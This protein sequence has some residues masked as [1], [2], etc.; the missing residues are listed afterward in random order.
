MASNRTGR[1][2]RSKDRVAWKSTVDIIPEFKL[3]PYRELADAIIGQACH[4]YVYT[5]NDKMLKEVTEFFE[6]KKDSWFN[7]ICDL[8][9]EYLLAA[10]RVE[11]TK[12]LAKNARL[13]RSDRIGKHRKL[14]NGVWYTA[15]K[16]IGEYED[17]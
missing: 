15:Q 17:E 5:N 3:M 1:P 7:E 6:C 9:N 10:L 11:R 4:D 12:R 8:D 16:I 14:I 13:N 2:K